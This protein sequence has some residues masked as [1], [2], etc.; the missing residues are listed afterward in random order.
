MVASSFL[1]SQYVCGHATGLTPT[2]KYDSS[3][4]AH[5]I[6]WCQGMYAHAADQ[7]CPNKVPVNPEL[8]GKVCET[9]NFLDSVNL[10]TSEPCDM[11]EFIIY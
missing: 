6:S 5:A 11:G 1:V 4:R 10:D 9:C 8:A 3:F 2:K 7:Q